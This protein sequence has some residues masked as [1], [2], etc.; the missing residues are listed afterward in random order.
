MKFKNLKKLSFKLNQLRILSKHLKNQEVAAVYNKFLQ[1]FENISTLNAMFL[2]LILLERSRAIVVQQS[3][4][5]SLKPRKPGE[6]LKKATA[7]EEERKL[8]WKDALLKTQSQSYLDNF[9]KEVNTNIGFSPGLI[10]GFQ[11]F[12]LNLLANIWTTFEAM[13]KDLWKTLLN[14]YPD[15]FYNRLQKPSSKTFMKEEGLVGKT[16]PIGLLAK[17]E[18]NIS[19]NLGDIVAFKYD[20]G[21]VSGI[22]QAFSAIFLQ[23]KSS[24]TFLDNQKLKELEYSRHVTVH[25]AGIVDEDFLRKTK[26]KKFRLDERLDFSNERASLMC[27]AAI[28]VGIK[29][30]KYCD[31]QLT[32]L[33]HPKDK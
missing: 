15:H 12:Q 26:Y 10:L 4:L 14:N 20:L 25:N 11:N 8:L 17:Y 22:R 27:N 9:F 23:K 7:K 6:K 5:D 33:L 13:S 18:F 3:L 16:I 1:N 2:S 31:S 21:S 28:Q 29:L 24:L 19:N 30:L 32:E